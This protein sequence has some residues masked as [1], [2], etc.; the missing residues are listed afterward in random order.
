M[1][2]SRGGGVE[3]LQASPGGR[4]VKSRARVTQVTAA[5]TMRLRDEHPGTV[6]LDCR[7]PN[8]WHLGHAM[9]ALFIPRGILESRVEA[10]IPPVEPSNPETPIPPHPLPDPPSHPPRGRLKPRVM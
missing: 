8:E 4:T 6:L 9:G 7:E 10:A 3:W 5:D 2:R 1:D